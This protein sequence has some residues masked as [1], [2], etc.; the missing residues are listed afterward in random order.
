MP[1]LEPLVHNS[2]IAALRELP[3]NRCE[4]LCHSPGH[5][6][7][8]RTV[9]AIEFV[10]G[11][12]AVGAGL[13]FLE[14]IRKDFDL[15]DAAQNL[16]YY[17][18][19]DPDRRLS[20][21]FVHAAARIMDANVTLVVTIAL[22]YATGRFIESYGLWRQRVWAEWLAIISGAI[23]LPFELYALIRHPTLVHWAI[24]LINIMVVVYIAWVRWDEVS[25]RRVARVRIAEEGD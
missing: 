10:K 18:N 14:L 9:A 22:L 19:I 11:L 6:K 17:L 24:L 23:Y 3:R 2:N 1:E 25:A 7:G 4:A 13:V 21:A 5:K 15:E 12:L 8:L 16:V 20:Q